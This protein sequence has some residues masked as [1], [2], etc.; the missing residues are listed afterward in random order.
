MY[1]AASNYKE[2]HYNISARIC[3][4]I[5]GEGGKLLEE[6]KDIVHDPRVREYVEYTPRVLLKGCKESKPDGI[7]IIKGFNRNVDRAI[8]YIKDNFN[9]DPFIESSSPIVPKSSAADPSLSLS[10][11]SAS[12]PPLSS[13]STTTS[14]A[15]ATSASLLPSTHTSYAAAALSAPQRPLVVASSSA[16][17]AASSIYKV[18]IEINS[19][20]CRLIK[21]VLQPLKKKF[22]NVRLQLDDC[23]E[24]NR[25]RPGTDGCLKISGNNSN[26]IEVDHVVDIIYD[27][28]ETKKDRKEAKIKIAAYECEII[29]KYL[30]SKDE[31]GLRDFLYKYYNTEYIQ[32]IYIKLISS[33][34]TKDSD[35]IRIG[36]DSSIMINGTREA[37]DRAIFEIEEMLK[38]LPTIEKKF[39]FG[40]PLCGF[41]RKNFSDIQKY[42][43]QNYLKIKDIKLIDCVSPTE[44]NKMGTKGYLIIK[45]IKEDINMV[46]KKILEMVKLTNTINTRSTMIKF[47]REIEQ[48]N[49]L[50]NEINSNDS[51]LIAGQ[52]KNSE[53]KG[54]INDFMQKINRILNIKINVKD[55]DEIFNNVYVY[56]IIEF[57]DNFFYRNYI[58]DNP[59]KPDEKMIKEIVYIITYVTLLICPNKSFND[60]KFGSK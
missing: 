39:V 12:F 1:D 8:R 4:R 33:D 13:T 9:L 19:K 2:V 44:E 49:I 29:E 7:L 14:A 6:L 17:S 53:A 43:R 48:F 10:L 52:V 34:E 40:H 25:G 55:K 58:I 50:I 47:Y 42:I 41:I 38:E 16:S 51:I 26:K 59:L 36:N 15:A 37:V 46:D 60:L 24:P 30:Y 21:R 27:I 23:I 35:D 28:L 57:T 56:E 20:E 31:E 3:S 54:K 32:R 11:S 18:S 22:P 45:G 5:I